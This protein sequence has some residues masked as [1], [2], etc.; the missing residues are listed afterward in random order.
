MNYEKLMRFMLEHTEESRL[1]HTEEI[2]SELESISRINIELATI[3]P[4]TMFAGT[5]F[6]YR[7]IEFVCLDVTDNKAL[8]ITEK[9]IKYMPFIKE[10]RKECD[11][12]KYSDINSWFNNSY[13]NFFDKNDLIIQTS[14][15]AAN[16]GDDSYG[17]A[18]NYI[19]I[20]SCEQYRKYRNLIP[21]HLDSIWTLTP[22]Y[23]HGH[24]MCTIDKYG[25]VV[26][27]DVTLGSGIAAVCLFNLENLQLIPQ[28]RYI[29]G[30]SEAV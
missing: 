29:L 9:A 28:T 17:T 7:D 13:I 6:V 21:K 18:E 20:L 16:N 12:W 27:R 15:L 14:N 19:T 23:S 25:D 3:A 30:H 5:H 26:N 8:A 11:N 1:K 10:Y 22:S 2:K 24:S 4:T